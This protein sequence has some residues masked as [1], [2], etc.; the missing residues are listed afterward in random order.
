MKTY[1]LIGEKL[2][3]SFSKTFFDDY[4]NKN[5]VDAAFIN[6]EIPTI[7]SIT[8]VFKKD[9]SGL[10]VT[11]PYKETIIP[12]LDE[13]TSEAKEIGAVNV[14][15]FKDGKRIG[16]N[17]DAYGFQQSIKPF[18]TN[19]HERALILGTGG[20]SKAVAHVFKSIGIDVIF[21]SRNPSGPKEFSYDLL[22]EHM[23]NA[24]KV[25]VNC[26]P[27]GTF[28][29]VDES[30]DFPFQFLTKDHLVVDLIY[31]PAKT[32]FLQKAE[33]VGATILNGE[34]MLK[35]QA[36]KAWEIWNEQ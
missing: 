33:E 3:Y 12:F 5:S 27:I 36:L 28:P 6:L 2:D 25:I 34:S 19:L 10:T 15:Q 18:L 14:I 24:C 1:G 20:A 22:N 30:I 13:I 4:F 26:T 17:S 32:K 21:C 31:N 29:N 23:V 35:E 7:D 11:I 8:E 16:H 9:I